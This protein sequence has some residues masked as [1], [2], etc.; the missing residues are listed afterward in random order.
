MYHSNSANRPKNGHSQQ[1]GPPTTVR[2]SNRYTIRGF[3]VCRTL[4]CQVYDIGVRTLNRL[5]SLAEE[6]LSESFDN[7]DDR[8]GGSRLTR[9]IS[10]EQSR[11]AVQGLDDIADECGLPD[12]GRNRSS[13][14]YGT[15]TFMPHCLSKAKIC[16]K[17]FLHT[18]ALDR[19]PIPYK[20]FL[21]IWEDVR[22]NVRILPLRF[23]MCS[24]HTRSQ[25]ILRLSYR[26]KCSSIN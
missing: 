19:E 10:Q 15:D 7:F 16:D 22:R 3:T 4:F 12:P 14:T 17:Y 18:E 11:R 21:S 25:N 26:R 24:T 2:T 20:S 8:R 13:P 5:S 9:M 23:D 1:L 6:M